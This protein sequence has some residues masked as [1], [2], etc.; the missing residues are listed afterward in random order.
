MPSCG[1][2]DQTE[3]ERQHRLFTG[4]RSRVHVVIDALNG[5]EHALGIEAVRIFGARRLLFTKVDE[6]ARP[7]VMLSTVMQAGY[8]P[9]Q[10]WGQVRV[11]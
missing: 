7:G 10:L 3:R 8:P 5:Y 6:V 1:P 4:R 9:T 11:I 2:N